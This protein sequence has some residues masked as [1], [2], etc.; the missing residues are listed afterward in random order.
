MQDEVPALTLVLTFT[1]S[2]LEQDSSDSAAGTY[3][4]G[5][6]LGSSDVPLPALTVVFTF[7][8][9][10]SLSGKFFSVVCTLRSR[11]AVGIND[12]SLARLYSA[13]HSHGLPLCINS[14]TCP[15]GTRL[16]AMRIEPV[17]FAG[18]DSC[19]HFHGHTSLVGIG[20]TSLRGVSVAR[21][22]DTYPVLHQP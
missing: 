20:Q 8:V 13:L 6:P 16:A 7:I 15:R 21:H 5:L 14:P 12:W 18:P 22:A 9:V 1:V 19:F 2:L 10:R 3:G 4:L 17:S 11:I